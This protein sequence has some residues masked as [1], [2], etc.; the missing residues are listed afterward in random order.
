VKDETGA[1]LVTGG[2][3]FI[4]S[5]VTDALLARGDE[6]VCLDNFDDFYDPSVKRRNLTAAL[7][8]PRFTLIEGD[9]R[10]PAALA[11]ALEER[12]IAKVF[13][14]AARAGVRPSLQ[15]PLLYE[16]INV[17]GTLQLLEACKG[18]GIRNFVFASSSSVYGACARIPF[19]ETEG[20][21][22]PISPYAA[23][24]LAGEY[25]CRTYAALY[26]FPVTCLRLFT[27]YGPRQRPEMAIHQFVRLIEGGAPVPVFGDGTARRDFTYI[28]DVVAGVLAALDRPQAFEVINLGESAVIEIRE[29]IR[30][31]E[32]A[33]GKT[34]RIDWRPAQ[35]GDVPVTFADIGKA[36]RVLGYAPRTGVKDGIAAFVRW[37]RSEAASK[38]AAS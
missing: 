19:R 20:D 11:R 34:A 36:V 38:A 6:V 14:A 31:I 32:E 28:D 2:A 15:A 25:L 3:G 17:R 33:L 35:A 23:T 12:R 5:H 16:E 8:S 9:L 22:S 1:T 30:L 4:G 27:V 18:R 37:Y 29:V 24:K 7:R 21:L 13:H 10:D 26:G